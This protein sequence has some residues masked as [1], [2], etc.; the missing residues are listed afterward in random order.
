MESKIKL[1]D[2][3]CR[4]MPHY[5]GGLITHIGDSVKVTV[6]KTVPCLKRFKDIKSKTNYLAHDGS[7]ICLNTEEDSSDL[8]LESLCDSGENSVKFRNQEKD[9]FLEVWSSEVNGGFVASY[10]A[11]KSFTKVYNDDTFGGVKWS[12]DF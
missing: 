10:K 6:K 3:M 5:S 12:N 2:Q 9:L 4:E 1:Y 8:V 7:I 11:S